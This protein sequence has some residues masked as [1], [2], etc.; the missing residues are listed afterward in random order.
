M[1]LQDSQSYL[2]LHATCYSPSRHIC[3]ADIK[4]V[5]EAASVRLNF[6]LWLPSY[7]IKYN[8]MYCWQGHEFLEPCFSFWVPCKIYGNKRLGYV[9][10]PEQFWCICSVTLSRYP[11]H[12]CKTLDILFNRAK[13]MIWIRNADTLNF[14]VSFCTVCSKC[15]WNHTKYKMSVIFV[16]VQKTSAYCLF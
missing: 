10:M 11:M 9:H 14:N 2:T 12:E 4:T 16:C 7:I 6:H 8:C 13:L 3:N 5:K 15:I 1:Y